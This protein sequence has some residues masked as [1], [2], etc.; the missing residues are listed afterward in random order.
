[1]ISVVGIGDFCSKLVDCLKQYPQYNIYKI[2]NSNNGQQESPDT[3]YINSLKNAEMYESI[4][5]N[6]NA[7]IKDNNSFV[8]VFVDGSEP[9]SGVVLKFLETLKTREIKIIY[10]CSDLQ[11]MS[12][13]EKTQ[14]K[15]CFNVLQEYA[16]SGL[17]KNI[18]L[19]DKTKLES[20][21]GN[22]SILDYEEKITNLIS[23]TYHMVNVY[24]NIKPILTNSIETSDVCRISTYG[25]GEIGGDNIKWFFDIQNI[26][27]IIYYFA[28]NSDTLKKEQKLLQNI[29]KQVK[30]KQVD[31]VNV[32]FGV[33]ETQYN[34]N[35]VY[36][37]ANTKIIQ[38]RTG[39]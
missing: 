9:I 26:N 27:N 34:E 3:L 39:A 32:M 20:I 13:L 29:K 5:V 15:V 36:C 16:R 33:Y 12:T 25:L 1:M 23:T 18:S 6:Y 28:I 38:T 8:N 14:D 11:L 30:D 22:I 24:S 31:N 35:Y 19:I 4:E 37:S 2:R 17:F 21:L 10:L 7:L